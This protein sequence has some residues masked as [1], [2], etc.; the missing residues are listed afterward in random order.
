MKLVLSLAAALILCACSSAPPDSAK[1]TPEASLRVSPSSNP[2][3]RHLEVVGVRITEKTPGKLLIQFGVVNHSDADLGDISL[4]VTLKTTTSKD[5]EP[6]LVSFKAKVPAVGPE[7]LKAV[8]VEV[9]SKLRP[10]ELPDWQFLKTDFR[11]DEPK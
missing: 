4:D 9:P 6:P 2:A 11:L 7:D 5:S 3:A 8:S 10:Y 1:K